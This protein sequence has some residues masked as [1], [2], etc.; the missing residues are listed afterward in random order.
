[1]RKLNLGIILLLTCLVVFTICQPVTAMQNQTRMIVPGYGDVAAPGFDTLTVFNDY[2]QAADLPE[3]FVMPNE[4]A[5]IGSFHAWLDLTERK[6]PANTEYYYGIELPMD[7]VVLWLYAK[8]NTQHNYSRLQKLNLSSVSD[9]MCVLNDAT[10]AAGITS[11]II[12]RGG[13][14]YLYG[15]G[16]LYSITWQTEFAALEINLHLI[17]A[18]NATYAPG[19][20][21]D[22]LLSLGEEYW[23]EAHDILMSLGTSKSSNDESTP[24]TGDP[25]L[26][27]AALLPTSA[28]GM[29][30]L[31]KK[32]KH[33]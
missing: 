2:L 25:I 4:L 21:M 1:M 17:D 32:K 11:G 15:G 7:E 23:N 20:F 14:T 3:G 29:A 16:K 19:S 27:F 10:I 9:D 26:L 22:K 30:L 8:H 5:A 13:L 33:T 12:Q 31:H 6:Q 24:G 28:A 18:G